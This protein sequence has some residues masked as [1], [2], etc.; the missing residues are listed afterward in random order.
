MKSLFCL[1]SISFVLALSG[2]V[3]AELI[4]NKGG[5]IYDTNLNITW[6]QLSTNTNM[7]WDE[8]MSWATGLTVGGV[9]GWRLPSALNKDGTGP[10]L[11]YNCTSSEMGHLFYNELGNSSSAGL[12]NKGPFTNLQPYYYWTEN[13]YPYFNYA[14][15]F[16]F[17]DGSQNANYKGLDGYTTNGY[18]LA[19]HDGDVL[20]NGIVLPSAPVPIPGSIFLLISGVTI[21]TAVRRKLRT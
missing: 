3:N 14:W 16:N 1:L 21:L 9:S 17:G 7:T 20:G 8:T 2:P 15:F 13:Q 5:L 18:G 11:G 19:V 10:C 4:D 12:Q 6:F